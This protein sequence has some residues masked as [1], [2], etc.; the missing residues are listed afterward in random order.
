MAMSQTGT[1]QTDTELRDQVE[2]FREW[3]AESLTAADQYIA[4]NLSDSERVRG[5][6]DSS[7]SALEMVNAMVPQLDPTRLHEPAQR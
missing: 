4:A 6:A 1:P 7:F 3:L 2:R 5:Q